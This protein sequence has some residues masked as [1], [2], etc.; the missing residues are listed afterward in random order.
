M[1]SKFKFTA[2]ESTFVEA[3]EERVK[4]RMKRGECENLKISGNEM[5]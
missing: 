3:C 1:D 2:E 4:N 5:D